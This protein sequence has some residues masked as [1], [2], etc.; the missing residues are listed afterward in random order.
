MPATTRNYTTESFTLSI[1]GVECGF[2]K[3]VEGGGISAEVIQEKAG[4]DYFPRKHLGQ[5]KYEDL[6]L[7]INLSMNV[8]V[9]Y[10]IAAVWNGSNVRK[11]LTISTV[12][13]EMN[14][15]SQR[16]L[17]HVSITETT[18]PTLDAT[19]KDPCYMTLKLAPERARTKNGS[20]KAESKVSGR[21]QKRWLPSNFR[22]KIVGL[23][24]TRI[25][26]VDA[27]TVKQTAATDSIG[28]SRDYQKEP[29]KLEFPNLKITLPESFAQSWKAWHEDFVIK[30]NNSE[31]Q[32]KNGFLAFL[33]P[34]HSKELA[35]INFF[36]LGIFRLAPEKTQPQQ[37]QV[38]KIVAELYC[39]RMEFVFP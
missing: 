39:Q 23:D 24:C 2:I 15:K 3:S 30:G 19:S 5:T 26:K 12:D 17:F 18:I 20:G 38:K 31:S 9:Y 34:D 21:T 22:L 37:D 10:W 28:E 29:G 33:T 25:S 13:H 1:G 6:L 7:Q 16:D 32:E 8:S 36:N 11:D 35:R 27:F 4:S 14:I